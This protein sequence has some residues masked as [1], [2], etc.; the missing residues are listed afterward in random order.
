MLTGLDNQGSPEE[1]YL[2]EMKDGQNGKLEK[3]IVPDEFSGFVQSG[4]CVEI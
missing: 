1:F 2:I 4:C 3:I